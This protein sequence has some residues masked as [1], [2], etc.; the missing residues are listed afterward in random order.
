MIHILSAALDGSRA[1]RVPA[2]LFVLVV[3]TAWG[4]DAQVRSRGDG[5]R[6]SE[7]RIPGRH[8]VELKSN[9]DSGAAAGALRAVVS[10]KR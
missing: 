7:H 5:S 9:V 4:A 2:V 8:V 1:C 10:R 3:G 6:R